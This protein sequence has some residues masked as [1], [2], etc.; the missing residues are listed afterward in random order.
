MIR[1]VLLRAR[2][3][4]LVL[5]LLVLA[6]VSAPAAGAQNNGWTPVAPLTTERMGH[7]AFV[8]ADGRVLVMGGATSSTASFAEIYDP[9]RDTWTP[10][11]G[12]PPAFTGSRVMLES[13]LVLIAGGARRGATGSDE[14]T[15]QAELFDPATGE[16][17]P[18]GSMITARTSAL[19]RLADGR[20]LAIGG[21]GAGDT[22]VTSAEIYDPATGEWTPAGEM[23]VGRS[24]HVAVVMRDGRVLVAGGMTKRDRVHHGTDSVEIYDPASNTWTATAS[25]STSRNGA[26]GALLDD[27]TVLVASGSWSLYST[28]PTAETYDPATDRWTPTG[29]MP[30]GHWEAEALRLPD[31]RVLVTGGFRGETAAQVYDPA[32]RSWSAVAALAPGRSGHTITL[33][34]DGRVLITGGYDGRSN[35]GIAQVWSPK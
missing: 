21:A 2:L 5:P 29:E 18:T 1:T 3:G 34:K 7:D 9:Q 17:R 8:L 6:A 23:S 11:G 26:V 13:G 31:G 15:N 33:L 12:P 16:R 22:L 14:F 25:L 27:G 30:K 35:L 20:V 32:T 28:E 4:A 10:I 24:A 19:T